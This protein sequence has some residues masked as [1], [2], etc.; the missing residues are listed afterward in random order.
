MKFKPCLLAF[1]FLL[2]VSI[3]S[4]PSNVFA[5]ELPERINQIGDVYTP[6]V[7]PDSPWYI[8]KEIRDQLKILLAT[9]PIRK[10]SYRLEAANK[11]TLE[12]QQLCEIGK[13]HFIKSLSPAVINNLSTSTKIIISEKG[14]GKDI[15]E[16]AGK[17]KVDSL[18]QISVFHRLYKIAPPEQKDLLVK[19]KDDIRKE[20]EAFILEVLGQDQLENFK[21][22]V[23]EINS[24]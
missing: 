2:A 11:K 24:M 22:S 19:T 14:R 9:D 12:L 6:K 1:F 21:K 10:A 4:S 15:S 8:L 16:I 5:I 23:V 17:V 7:L 13:C 18:K 3:F 20:T